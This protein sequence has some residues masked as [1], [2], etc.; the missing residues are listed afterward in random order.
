MKPSFALSLSFEGIA[1]LHRAAGGWNL[2]GEVPLDVPD[3]AVALADLRARALRIDPEGLSCKL[4]IPNDQIRYMQ[5]ETGQA[6]DEERLRQVR[7]ALEGATPYAVDDLAFDIS[8]EGTVTHIAA[9]ARETLAEAETFAA[10]HGFDPVSVVAI[11]GDQSFLGEPFF[12]ATK[13][14]GS[15]E[16]EPDGI[17]V[18]ITG[19]APLPEPEPAT[20]EP[21][22]AELSD[23]EPTEPAPLEPASEEP[24]PQDP[25]PAAPELPTATAEETPAALAEMPETQPETQPEEAAENDMPPE[26]PQPETPAV[27]APV[28]TKAPVAA[29]A[30]VGFASRRG[31]VEGGAK[32]PPPLAGV[33]RAEATAVAKPVPPPPAS[34]TASV[35]AAGPNARKIA[36]APRPVASKPQVSAGALL[37]RSAAA[38]T[39]ATPDKTEASKGLVDRKAPRGTGKPRFLGLILTLLLLLALAAVAAWATFFSDGGS[40]RRTQQTPT[41]TSPT[42]IEGTDSAAPS[43]AAVPAEATE[44]AAGAAPGLTPEIGGLLPSL[45][46]VDA[47][48]EL[49]ELTATDSAVLDALRQDEAGATE[50]T[51]EAE[52]DP[53]LEPEPEPEMAQPE[54]TAEADAET[55]YAATGIWPN[56]PEALAPPAVE[57]D[58]DLYVASIDPADLSQDAVALPPSTSLETDGAPNVVTSPAAAGRRFKLDARGLV[59]ATPEGNENPDGVIVT[60]GRPPAV[61]PALP[62][63]LTAEAETAAETDALRSHL[64][65]HRPRP[66][67]T[68]LIEQTER[69]QLGGR[70]RNELGR[71]RARLRPK[72]VEEAAARAATV[73]AA[74]AAAAAAAIAPDNDVSSAT[75]RAVATAPVP[76]ARPA[77]LPATLP[78]ET[79]SSASASIGIPSQE[80]APAPAATPDQEIDEPE[81]TTVAPSLPSSASVAREATVNRAINLRNLNLIGVYGSASNRRALIRLPNGRY[82]KVKV[83]DSIEGGKVIAIG[84]SELRYSKGG[85]SLTLKL[86]KG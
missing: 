73:T 19:T 12:G 23:P 54:T 43:S 57:G 5:L 35:I 26:A 41:A 78:T 34:A 16:V 33:R 4:I 6:E 36:A 55:L 59:E 13:H 69:A 11:P 51:A 56:A 74:A 79:R 39:A 65:G 24:E 48:P 72:S 29:P 10:D 15:R 3:L 49:P 80:V 2:V 17:A 83:G 25:E 7:Q 27:A 81:P 64:T 38:S 77:N 75:A 1:L 40:L 85:R 66:R 71:V 68:D 62:V 28:K 32:T 22:E 70:S 86:P 37:N 9:V 44:P 42:D 61:P 14:A 84:E 53:E 20:L 63:R 60:L 50:M 30:P 52:A 82:K 18:V 8:V 47:P 58:D 46:G 76:K 67:P 45:T 31:K 21:A